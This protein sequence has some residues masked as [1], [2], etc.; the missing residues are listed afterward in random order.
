MCD[1]DERFADDWTNWTT[2]IGLYAA[3][4]GPLSIRGLLAIACCW[5]PFGYAIGVWWVLRP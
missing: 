5:I 3:P 1:G 4:V 2:P